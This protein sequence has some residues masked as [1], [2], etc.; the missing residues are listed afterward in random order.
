MSEKEFV[1]CG[2]VS[3]LRFGLGMLLADFLMLSQTFSVRIS[4]SLLMIIKVYLLNL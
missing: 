4:L 1:S 2:A 3:V